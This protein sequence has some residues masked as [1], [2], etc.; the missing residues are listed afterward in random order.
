MSLFKPGTISSVDS[1]ARL[2]HAL[3]NDQTLSDVRI[4]FNGQHIF[5]HKAILARQSEY[6]FRAFTGQFPVASSGTISL[7]DDDDPKAIHAMIRHLYDLPYDQASV[8]FANS[9]SVDLMFHINVFEVADKYDVPSLRVLAVGRFAWLMESIWSS[10]K[11]K[12]CEAIQR[13]CAPNAVSFADRS[14][15][16]SAATFCS[17]HILDLIKID[18]F[19]KMLEEGEPF[20]GR[21]LTAV[22]RGKS[23]SVIQTKK[24]DKC[25]TVSD[26]TIQA[27]LVQK[28]ISCISGPTSPNA[29]LNPHRNV[30]G[31]GG[32]FSAGFGNAPSLQHYKNFL[33]L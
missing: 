9:A 23:E 32:G 26:S 14:L 16:A 25:A 6:F 4:E 21:L 11:E 22:L 31:F 30:T 24:C 8:L 27:N 20:A 18:S 10:K 5:G 7:G 17:A 12:V 3:F 15:Q 1:S 13:L 29:P 28:C 33:P 19:V 2:S